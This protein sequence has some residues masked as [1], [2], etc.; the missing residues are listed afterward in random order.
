MQITVKDL[1]HTFLAKTPYE[2]NAIDNINVSIKQGEFVGVIGQTGSGKTT[3][4]EHLNALLL[5]SAGS[6]EWVFE[7]D[8][9]NHKTGEKEKFMESFVIKPTRRKRVKKAKDLRKRVGVVFQFAEYQLFEETIEKDIAFGPR[10]FGVSKQEALERAAKYIKLVGL[11]ESFLKRSPFELSGGQKRRVAL[12]GILAM[13]PDFIIADEPTAGLDPVGVI[14]ILNIFK[15]LHKQGKTVIIVTHDLDNVL[16]YTERVLAFKDGQIVK[17]GDTHDVLRDT[18][19]L[20]NNYMEPPKLLDF[21]SK[22]EAKGIKVPRVT[23]I[24]ELANFIN[25]YMNKKTKG[26][27]KDE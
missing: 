23:S 4:I 7:N 2:L 22:L 14:E 20:K 12:A 16:E 27:V 19:F 18:E 1:V 13:E 5:P 8:K 26:G 15:E 17:D 21:V 6:V 10:S 3:F 24:D 9:I 25:K 11:D